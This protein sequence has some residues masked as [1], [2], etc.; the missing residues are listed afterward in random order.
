MKS[1]LIWNAP[2]HSLPNFLFATGIENSSPL[3]TDENGKLLRVDEMEKTGH[4]KRWREDFLK[5]KEMGLQFLRYGPAY[6]KTHLG[7]GR[8]DWSFADETLHELRKMNITPIAD[9]CHFGIPGWLGNFQNPEWPRFFSEYADA[10]SKRFPW[11][12][13]Y[14]PINEI[15][16]AAQFSAKLG[17]WNEQLKSDYAFVTALKNLS[18]ANLL[19]QDSIL[20]NN[21]KALFIQSESTEYFHPGRPEALPQ[22]NF[23]NELRFV[24]LDL[25]YGHDVL[26]CTYEYLLDNGMTRTE[27]HWLLD[28]GARMKERCVMG[29]DYY[30]S[31]EHLVAV[32]GKLSPSGEIFGYYVIT[33]QYYDRYHLSVMHTETNLL[34]DP[35]HAAQWLWKEWANVLRLKQDGVPIIGFTWYSLL[36]QVDWDTVLRQ[37]NG[38]VNRLGLFDLDRNIRPVGKAYKK[39]IQQWKDVLA[40][41][42]FSL[43]ETSLQAKNPPAPIDDLK[44][45]S[46]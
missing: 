22:A 11:I 14:T 45:H 37:N 5:V 46:I 40:T 33:K 28:N 15:F 19:A 42:N 13:I 32:D 30:Q 25:N 2:N 34:D 24:S 21:S 29:N 43:L 4:D 6:Y 20:K 35:E 17:H 27:Y 39:L 8:Y 3:I 44:P 1:N 41:D 10:F 12:Q 36:D 7:P 9:L 23:L 18:R 16:I 31:N 38:R 26:S